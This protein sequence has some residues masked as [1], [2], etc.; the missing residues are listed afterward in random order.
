MSY[1]V[2]SGKREPLGKKMFKH[3]THPSPMIT[4]LV[5]QHAGAVSPVQHSDVERQFLAQSPMAKQKASV[6]A[7]FISQGGEKAN[8]LDEAL[9]K[10]MK[11]NKEERE[12]K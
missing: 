12:S 6:M 8:V 9:V 11:L 7:Q 4:E 1:D 5:Q 3:V 2:S 10:A